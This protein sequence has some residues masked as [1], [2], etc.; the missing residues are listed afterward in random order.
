MK[1]TVELNFVIY[2]IKK[3]ISIKVLKE[4]LVV[5]D[6]AEAAEYYDLEEANIGK[7]DDL[8]ETDLENSDKE[9]ENYKCEISQ[10]MY[11]DITELMEHVELCDVEENKKSEE[12]RENVSFPYCQKLFGN[13]KEVLKHLEV[14]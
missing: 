9:A 13:S 7:M 5:K 1:T 4:A 11:I 8:F 12:D 2:L 14:H 6:D 3:N 10:K